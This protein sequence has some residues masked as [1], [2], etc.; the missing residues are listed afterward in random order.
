MILRCDH[1]LV[2]D[3][4]ERRSLNSPTYLVYSVAVVEGSVEIASV[5]LMASASSIGIID[6]VE[7][8]EVV[9]RDSSGVVID[10]ERLDILQSCE[11]SWS[12]WLSRSLAVCSEPSSTA[13]KTTRSV[14]TSSSKSASESSSENSSSAGWERH[15]LGGGGIPDIKS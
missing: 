14:E 4:R 5:R 9:R 3:S 12:N 1:E 8:E 13:C 15:S 2:V 10:G 7:I 6:G 11:S